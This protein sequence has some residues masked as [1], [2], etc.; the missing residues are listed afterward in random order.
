MLCGYVVGH[1]GH[2]VGKF[3]GHA[4][5]ALSICETARLR[6]CESSWQTEVGR[7]S[8]TYCTLNNAFFVGPKTRPAQTSSILLSAE[9]SLLTSSKLD[10]CQMA[11][12]V[13]NHIS[14]G[15]QSVVCMVNAE[16]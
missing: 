12:D 16:S 5:R 4:T 14:Y 7:R 11:Q 2:A 15:L 13:D 9:N 6:D 8:V 3:K 10:K 1:A